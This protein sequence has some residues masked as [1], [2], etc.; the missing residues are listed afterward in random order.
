MFNPQF[1]F[2][3]RSHNNP[4]NISDQPAEVLTEPL[5]GGGGRLEEDGE[6]HRDDL[7]NAEEVKNLY[8][9]ICY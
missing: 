2:T 6:G 1:G 4:T 3:F 8:S 7:E 9:N 5:Q